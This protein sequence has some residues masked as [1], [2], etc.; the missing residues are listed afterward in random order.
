MAFPTSME[1]KITVCQIW[2]V[3]KE[4]GKF[5]LKVEK[6]RKPHVRLFEE[7]RNAQVTIPYDQRTKWPPL[8]VQ[9]SGGITIIV[10][11]LEQQYKITVQHVMERKPDIHVYVN[12]VAHD[13]DIRTYVREINTQLSHIGIAGPNLEITGRVKATKVTFE[14]T[15]GA[16][17]ISSKLCA[18]SITLNAQSIFINTEAL[19][20]CSKLRMVSRRVQIDGRICHWDH[21]SSKMVLFIDTVLLHIGVDGAIGT[22]RSSTDRSTI[23]ISEN[24]VNVLYF[25]LTGC[26]ANFGRIASQ[27]EMEFRVDGSILSLQDSRIDSASRG[28]TALKQ[29]KG[30]TSKA[31]NS[32]PTSSTLGFAILYEKPEAVAQL[33]EDGV[34]VNDSIGK[35]DAD[36]NT[37]RRIA[38]KKYKEIQASG[39]RNDVREKITLIQALIS[40]HDWRR[41]TISSHNINAKIGRDCA[42]CAQFRSTTLSLTIYGNAK[43]EAN[44]I[45]ACGSVTLFVGHDLIIEGQ[46]KHVNLDILCGDNVATTEDAVVSQE[47]WVKV[48]S[49]AFCVAGIWSVGEQFSLDVRSATFLEGSYLEVDYLEGAIGENCYNSGTWQ[50]RFISLSIGANL[51]I[52]HTGKVFVANTAIINAQSLN[53]CGLWK[54]EKSIK[55][56]LKASANF[57][58]TSKFS[59][60]MLKLIVVGQCTVAGQLLLDNLL[61][62]VRNDMV[63]APGAQISIGIGATIAAGTFRNN[64]SWNLDGNFNLHVACFE[65]SEDALVF[66][67]GTLIMAI[68]DLSEECCQGRIVANYFIMKLA[69]KVRFDCYIRVNQIEICVPHVNESRCTIGGQLEVLNGPLI[70]KGRSFEDYEGTYLYS[71]SSHPYPAFVLDG[72]LKAEAVIAPFSAILFSTSS[73]SLLSGMNSIADEAQYRVLISCSSLH[74]QHAS[75]I[76]SISQDPFPE[77]IMCA[78]NWLHEGQIRFHGDKVYIVSGTI[79]NRGRLTSGDKLQNHMREVIVHVANF[80]HNDAVFSADRIQI[81]GNGELHNKNRIFAI[82]QMDIRLASFNNKSGQVQLE[83]MQPKLLLV[84]KECFQMG[85]VIEARGNFDALTA[86]NCAPQNRLDQNKQLHM[87][88]RS[89]LLVDR[90]LCD[91]CI[92]ITLKARDAIIFKSKIIVNLVEL[93]LGVA[94]NTEIVI[95]KGTL[96]KTNQL[97]ITGSC[98]YLTLAIDGELSCNSM[99]IDATI[100]QVKVLGNGRLFCRKTWNVSSESITL[101]TRYICMNELMGLAVTI[102]SNCF[103]SLSPY[104]SRLKSIC[105]Y[106]DSC[107]LRGQIFVEHK[108]VLRMNCGVVNVDGV[109]VGTCANSELCLEC[110]DLILTGTVTNLDF[111]ECYTQKRIEHCQSGVIKGVKN[112]VFEGEFISLDGKVVDSESLVATGEEVI[113]EG[114]FRY[115]SSK[116]VAYSIFGKKI[117]FDGEACGLSS[118]ELNGS[119]VTIS[120]ISNNLKAISIDAKRAIVAP[121]KLHCENFNV[122]AHSVVLDGSFIFEKIEVVAHAA[123]F[124]RTELTSCPVC[125]LV[126]P[127]VLALKCSI[128]NHVDI[129]SFICISEQ[130]QLDTDE[131]SMDLV[132]SKPQF[133]T[134]TGQSENS[135]HG[136][137]KTFKLPHCNNIFAVQSFI[138]VLFRAGIDHRTSKKDFHLWKNSVKAV[139]ECF[140]NADVTRDELMK[141]LKL[142]ADLRP[143]IVFFP[144]T[145]LLH[146]TLMKLLDEI[147][148]AH[149]AMCHFAKLLTLLCNAETDDFQVIMDDGDANYLGIEAFERPKRFESNP[150]YEMASDFK[151]RSCKYGLSR[152][153]HRSIED[154]VGYASRSSSEDNDEKQRNTDV[155]YLDMESLMSTS[156][157]IIDDN[158]SLNKETVTDD[159]LQLALS[160][161]DV[162]KRLTHSTEALSD[163]IGMSNEAE[164]ETTYVLNGE[165]RIPISYI[166]FNRLD[167]VIEKPTISMHRKTSFR[168]DLAYKKIQVKAILP[169]NSF[170]SESSVVSLDEIS[171]PMRQI[172]TPVE[173]SFI[174]RATTPVNNVILRR[175]HLT[176][177]HDK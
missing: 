153:K 27:S 177:T 71:T 150:L 56:N 162:R 1:S 138:Q 173:R 82:D 90:D 131:S 26:L 54:I 120:G 156:K 48:A 14:S 7:S 108:I 149:I 33:L 130:F 174:P 79:V 151:I 9:M 16:L 137:V 8:R 98:Q 58:A 88:S 144:S 158:Y 84:N 114:V 69:K 157:L 37:P 28:Y 20:V 13:R 109:I 24:I 62:Y 133:I 63:T 141:A 145:C 175:S 168:T 64:C 87:S 128:S 2:M 164:D 29:I 124:V 143:I 148:I 140:K 55:V 73:Y 51:F 5:Y 42:D 36:E 113:I 89:Q 134:M 52:L 19:C 101:T 121:R 155:G 99:I 22:S 45:W 44:S 4:A 60:N 93:T 163:D 76:D 6:G 35:G 95:N 57:Y 119:E 105:I 142:T 169:Q 3:T 135:E 34:D 152:T 68:Y 65:Q 31:S 167:V 111:L 159:G 66:V 107:Y 115:R 171:K 170:G 85:G 30:I 53:N 104:D 21:Q 100:R 117:Y 106:A 103:L 74:T 129:C 126:A 127:L 110:G 61:A 132:E 160:K 122:V 91:S 81:C 41:G 43:C 116:K 72:Q 147:H 118:L 165:R 12:A 166:N 49:S 83:E 47:Q 96:L 77:G 80:F 38:A 59:A 32:L 40:T 50:T 39:K 67:K 172:P 78:T 86:R 125:K 17:L 23:K 154:D 102:A 10:Q 11:R 139:G 25:R 123:I 112:I 94:Y 18:R 161:F 15:V 97:R 146:F 46:V 75:L 92:D 70:L 176:T 136:D